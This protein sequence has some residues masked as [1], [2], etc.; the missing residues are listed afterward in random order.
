MSSVFYNNFF[1]SLDVLILE[2]V[3]ICIIFFL[4]V[5]IEKIFLTLKNFSNHMAIK[6]VFLFLFLFSII[7]F[8]CLNFF[9]LKFFLFFF[10]F[11]NDTFVFFIKIFLFFLFM[12][13]L[14][15]SYIY[16]KKEKV[17]FS[18][19]I[20]LLFFLSILSMS[21]LIS[22]SELLVLYLSLEMQSLIFY[23]L[24]SLKQNSILSIEAG[25]KYFVLGTIASGFLLLGSSLFYGYTGFTKFFEINIFFMFL[26]YNNSFFFFFFI[27]FIVPF[28]FKFSVAPFHIWTPDV[29]EGSPTIVTFFFS[30]LPKLVILG[31]LI[32]F[33]FDFFS[34]SFIEKNWKHIFIFCSFF[35][36][37]LGSIG[38]IFQLKIK[39]LLAYSSITNVGFFLS[40]IFTLSIEGYISCFFYFF[41]YFV[42]TSGIFIILLTLRY[43]NNL[44][45]LKNIFEYSSILNVNSFLSFSLILN[46]FSLIGIPPLAGFFGKLFIFFS[47]LNNDFLSLI[48]FL[49]LASIFSAFFYLRVIRI[50]MFKRFKGF[51]L[52]API[53][54]SI[55]YFLSL[56]I[57]LNIFLLFFVDYFFKILYLIYFYSFQSELI[58]YF[59]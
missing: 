38:G 53:E 28:F 48:I 1:F 40:C 30:I 36:L 12:I 17:L 27:F 46:F 34:I 8:Y 54:L 10:H 4:Y 29:Y 20:Y 9:Q 45:K 7:F 19:E 57:F 3:L 15:L 44:F 52:F 58:F 2:Y 13:F 6:I 11:Y 25:L 56:I 14:Y 23:V 50:V 32:R 41:V 51:V 59:F 24:S 49:I 5:G 47:V 18:F 55:V 37:I 22:S 16:L 43:F 39:R 33:F 21:I 31:L 26:D 42:S 35:S